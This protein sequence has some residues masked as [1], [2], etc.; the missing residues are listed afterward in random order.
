MD[1]LL[2]RRKWAK[3]PLR[4]TLSACASV[5]AVRLVEPAPFAL[6][7]AVEKFRGSPVRC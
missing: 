7:A 6:T 2:R 3:G 5:L 4:Q 1:D